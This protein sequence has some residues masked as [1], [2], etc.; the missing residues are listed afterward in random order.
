MVNPYGS[1]RKLTYPK[2]PVLTAIYMCLELCYV[3]C[4]LPQ[5]LTTM[6]QDRIIH[7]LKVRKLGTEK[8][9]DLLR[10]TQILHGKA[11]T[12]SWVRLSP[13]SFPCSLH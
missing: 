1:N 10:A 13:K 4:M 8:L 5:I 2:S 12:E 11:E 6:L 7:I 3:F 9:S